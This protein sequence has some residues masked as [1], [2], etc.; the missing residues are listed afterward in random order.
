M[1][2]KK[3]KHY[4]SKHTIPLT[5]VFMLLLWLMPMSVYAAVT[6]APAPPSV[7]KTD[8]T[9]F[10]RNDGSITKVDETMEYRTEGEDEYLPVHS[11]VVE[12]LADGKY[13]VRIKG[14]AERE[15]SLD[16]AVIIKAGKI[17]K[18]AARILGDSKYYDSSCYYDDSELYEDSDSEYY[19]GSGSDSWDS[20]FDYPSG[21][22]PESGYLE[23]F[24]AWADGAT[25]IGPPRPMTPDD[26]ASPQTG[27]NPFVYL[28]ITLIFISGGTI[29][30]VTLKDEL[31][32]GK[33]R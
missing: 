22:F 14:N 26:T 11:T 10:G 8:E 20:G 7:G 21:V 24:D 16:T 4:I 6:I 17:P 28:V 32:A 27:E 15:P 29:L 33:K 12:N 3:I 5:I 23:H 1:T 25:I 9:V 13:Y 19:F 18:Y 31:F 30:L 2:R